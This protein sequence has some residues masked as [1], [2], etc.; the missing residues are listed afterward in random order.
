MQSLSLAGH[1]WQLG[2]RPLDCVGLG[3]A[4]ALRDCDAA[5]AGDP[6]EREGVAANSQRNRR[7]KSKFG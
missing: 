5:V 7:K 3:M 1:C 2:K 4:V 6:C